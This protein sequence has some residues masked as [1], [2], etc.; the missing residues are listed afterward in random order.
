[1]LHIKTIFFCLLFLT[2]IRHHLDAQNTRLSGLIRYEFTGYGLDDT[3]NTGIVQE[4]ELLY[5]DKEISYFF[6]N[7]IKSLNNNT[8]ELTSIE[9]YTGKK[10]IHQYQHMDKKL[11]ISL[12]RAF[13]E[14]YLVIDTMKVIEWKLLN[15]SKKIQNIECF[16]AQAE[17]RGRIWTAWYAPSIPVSS[18]PWKL[19]GLP[20]MI[21]EATDMKNCMLF[22]CLAVVAPAP[23]EAIIEIPQHKDKKRNDSPINTKAFEIICEKDII[24]GEKMSVKKEGKMNYA[25]SNIEIFAF[26]KY[27]FLKRFQ[28]KLSDIPK[29]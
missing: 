15:K 26:E 16:S 7:N 22:K 2:Q 13:R 4:Y 17:Y 1:M 5:K 29:K 25:V 19:Y 11:V 23:T 3:L 18:G 21:L 28:Q 24:N 10:Y 20:G 12:E 27:L 9:P 6:T 14:R 8:P